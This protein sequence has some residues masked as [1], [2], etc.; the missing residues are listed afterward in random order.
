MQCQQVRSSMP[1][2]VF[3]CFSSPYSWTR[4]L[5]NSS[6]VSIF[7]R[8]PQLRF[9]TPPPIPSTIRCQHAIRCWLSNGD[10]LI[11]CLDS[12]SSLKLFHK[13]VPTMYLLKRED[14]RFSLAEF[15]GKDIPCY[16]ILSHTWGKDNEEVN[17]KDIAD[18][19]SNFKAKPGYR[20]LDFCARQAAKDNLQYFWIDTC[21]I[22]R[23]NSAELSEAIN[24]MFRWYQNS[25]KCYVYLSDV[26]M[27]ES[28][29]DGQPCELSKSRWKSAFQKSRWFT[30]GWTLQELLAPATV[31][32]FSVEGIQLG[33][34]RSMEQRIAE[35]TGVH[36]DALRGSSLSLFSVD[37]RRSWAKGRE[38]KREEDAAYSL[39][40]IFD[41]HIP[42]IYGEG[43]D[44]ALRRLYKEIADQK[45]NLLK[46]PVAQGAS[47]DSRL[48]ENNA[49]CLPNTRVEL[50]SK[51]INWANNSDEKCIFWLN[52]MAGTG[53]STIARTMASS[54]AKSNQLGAS[55]FFKK[56]EGD[57]DNAN[58]FFTT[59]AKQLSHALPNVALAVGQAIEN[60]PD[61]PNKALKDQFEKL[62]LQPLYRLQQSS[63][64]L[65]IIVIVIDALDEC[66]QEKDIQTILWLLA[67]TK[68]VKGIRIRL[69]VTSRPELPIRLSFKRLP[70]VYQDLILHEV[71]RP[72]VEHDISVFLV[73]E[74]KKIQEDRYPS[75]VWPSPGDIQAL[76]KMATPLFIFAATVCRFIADWRGNPKRRL[77]TVLN[78]QAGDEISKLDKTY[79]PILNQLCTEQDEV[80]RRV[81][82]EEFREI[83]GPIIV[84]ANPLSIHSLASI[85]VIPEDEIAHRLELLHSVL[86]IPK[87]RTTSIKLLHLSFR[88]FLLN[89]KTKEKT[90][91]WISEEEVHTRL[92]IQCIQLL[93]NTKCL[94]R[95][96]C[97][98]QKPGTKRSEINH[99]LI[100]QH[101]PP[102][103]Q[104]ACRY[105]VYHL[106][107]SKSFNNIDQAYG[108]LQE[109]LLYWLEAL[110][111]TGFA[112][113]SIFIV[114][115][116][117]SILKVE[118]ICN[119]IGTIFNVV[120]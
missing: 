7:K 63:P 15:L 45:V 100:Q 56:G 5:A 69:L 107:Q 4:S 111:L 23:S 105:W 110:A 14:G 114:D 108:F 55:F 32:F 8:E 96:I 77:K 62:I 12:S 49:T 51:I 82:I 94:K 35:I 42:L 80:E 41:V 17:F 38:T 98:L 24:S 88:D 22:D 61:I 25:T 104:Y 109:R 36:V 31:K 106:Q 53:K 65:S 2:K 115:I 59:I 19:T 116:L 37:E 91:F 16:A 117:Q 47:F 39:L 66:D 33:D 74:F 73:H 113:E 93:L 52:G 28:A 40:G 119:I 95:D 72:T 90:K 30:R 97:N 86:S 84:L 70:G 89:P 99:N 120:D 44:N 50:Q 64:K 81:I 85:L 67:Q 68:E 118:L 10:F 21:C 101:L 102:D 78:Y 6:E 9:L 57:R 43:K 46:L 92:S 79:L 83:V 75:S 71:P 87:D 3:T 103:V 11:A 20:K 13:F 60:D 26:S 54:F 76:V 58:K 18:D 112:T 34:K 1:C 29:R 27:H 48:E